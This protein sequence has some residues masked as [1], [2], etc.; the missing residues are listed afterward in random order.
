MTTGNFSRSEVIELLK[1]NVC[2]VQ[3]T[4]RD[5]SLRVL[6]GTL[7]AA[8]LPDPVGSESGS[9][10]KATRN[11]ENNVV[12]FDLENEAWRTFNIER[13]NEIAVYLTPNL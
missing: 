8:Y 3:F 11:N 1:E 2:K 12:V 7:N 9:E 13:L 6:K 10:S 4:K 5:G